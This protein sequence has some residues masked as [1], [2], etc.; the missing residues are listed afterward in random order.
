MGIL[1]VGVGLGGVGYF[2]SLLHA[3]NHSLVKGAL[4]LIA[5]NI[6][7]VYHTK[8]SR[9]VVGLGRRLP[10]SGAMWMA[11]FLAITGSPPF[12]PF[13]SELT[14]L[15]AALDQERIFVGIAYL[16]LLAVIFI[17]MATIVLHMYQGHPE[18]LPG[19]AGPRA[20][21]FWSL[22]PSLVLCGLSL[23]LGLWLPPAL[24]N[25]LDQA[26]QTLGGTG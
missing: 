6:L 14:I 24:R 3:V 5:G 17:G 21:P 9:K 23:V 25:L 2:G 26:A 22:V 15:K 13:L 10:W 18:L 12:G 16:G 4:F 8:E 20:E 7:A 11:G 1:A 19:D